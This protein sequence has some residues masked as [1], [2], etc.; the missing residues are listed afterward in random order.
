MDSIRRNPVL[1]KA[2]M[3]RILR[4]MKALQSRIQRAKPEIGIKLSA[5]L[6]VFGAKLAL[7]SVEYYA[8][9][10]Q[11]QIGYMMSAL[12]ADISQMKGKGIDLER[13]QSE[14]QGQLG[15]IH[16]RLIQIASDLRSPNT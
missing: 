9:Q 7:L 11:T 10:S 13:A 15:E 14:I 5:G 1:I 2:D 4:Q 6:Q 16:S 3:V 12:G 8:S